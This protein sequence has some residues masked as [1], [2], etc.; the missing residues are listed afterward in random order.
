MAFGDKSRKWIHGCLS[1][2]NASVLVNGNPTTEFPVTRGVRQGD[3]LS[4]FLFII[5]MEGLHVAAQSAIDRHFIQGVKLPHAGPTISHLFY[6]DDAIFTGNWDKG[7]IKNLSRILKCFEMTSGLKV[8]FHKSRLFGIHT[9]ES[10]LQDMEQVLGCFNVGDLLS[11]ILFK[12]NGITLLTKGMPVG[13]NMLLKN[14]WKP[15]VGKFQEKLS[16][17]KAKTLLF[18]GRLTLIKSVLGSLST[19]YLSLFKAPQGVMDLL[20]RL[21]RRFLWGGTNEKRKMHWVDW[22][23]VV[24]EKKNGGLGIGTLKAQN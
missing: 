20:E 4:P 7:S 8:N 6:E 3:P 23:K 10:E 17:W 13:A 16:N 18:G 14:N 22:S 11:S 2:A 1:S 15:I 9:S 21:R 12:C 19:Y 5:A 24:A